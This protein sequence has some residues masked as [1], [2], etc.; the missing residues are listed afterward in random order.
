MNPPDYDRAAQYAL[1]RLERELSP[2]YT[3]H[4]LWHTRDDVLPGV[5]RLALAEGVSA[6]DLLLLRTAALFHDIGFVVQRDE[7][8]AVG[9]RIAREAL[10]QFDY[11]PAQIALID[12][13][14]M[15]T[16]LP[17]SPRTLLE[18][19]LADADLDGLGRAD[20]LNRGL[21]LRMELSAFGIV[22]TDSEWWAG[23]IAFIESH[24]Y[25]TA[26][27]R[28]LRDEQKQKNL[29]LLLAIDSRQK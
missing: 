20:F 14:I 10:P 7:H 22:S 15:A 11:S 24:R 26:A 16:K 13:M 2:V 6:D 25:F 3:Y 5:E 29:E 23:Q 21:S 28:A 19:I 1:R 17:Q 9:A 12:G 4:S 18:Q 27:A 8:E